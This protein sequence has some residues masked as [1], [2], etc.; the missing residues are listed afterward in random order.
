MMMREEERRREKEEG[1]RELERK[2]EVVQDEIT[3]E[4]KLQQVRLQ[5][6]LSNLLLALFSGGGLGERDSLPAEAVGPGEG[7]QAEGEGGGGGQEG[8]GQNV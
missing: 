5:Q 4:K 7:A 8:L 2:M 6:N 1:R 3:K